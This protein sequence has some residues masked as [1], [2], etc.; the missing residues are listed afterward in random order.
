[1]IHIYCSKKLHQFVGDVQD[2]PPTDGIERNL[3]IWNGHLFYLDRKKCLVFVNNLTHY[4]VFM[5]DFVKKDLASFETR[6]YHRLEEQLK[7]DQVIA[8]SQDFDALF[9]RD[10]FEFYKTNNDRKMTGR[11]NDLV[12]TFKTYLFYKYNSLIEMRVVYENGLINSRLNKGIGAD[13]NR[14]V[15]AIEVF[16]KNIG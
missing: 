4:A 16:K 10:G 14:Y 2:A 13:K 1:M 6:F 9:P 7:N 15:R 8:N 5:P 11:I 3:N 12:Q